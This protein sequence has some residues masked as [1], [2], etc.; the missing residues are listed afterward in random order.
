MENNDFVFSVVRAERP[1]IV[2]LY[3]TWRDYGDFLP[4][5]TDL[6][7]KLRLLRIPRIIIMG[8][9]PRWGGGLPETV[10]AYYELDPLHRLIPMRT[11]FR[12][13]GYEEQKQ[14][15][16]RVE[17]MGTE[18]I[19]AWDALCKRNECLTRV[20]ESASDLTA[21]DSAHLTVAGASYLAEAI[22]PCL[23]PGRDGGAAPLFPDDIDPSLVCHRPSDRRPVEGAR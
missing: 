12:L 3:S 10:Y 18:Y 21:F 17:P 14:F 20:G 1:D 5:L 15:R 9:P 7:A 22:A 13:V 11:N 2:L 6:I 8:P 23:F 16:D 19:S 4:N